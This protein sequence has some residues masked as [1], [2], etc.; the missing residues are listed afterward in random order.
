MMSACPA[1]N[2]ARVSETESVLL[3]AASATL[4]RPLRLDDVVAPL[5]LLGADS[6]GIIELTAAVEDAIGVVVPPDL[7]HESVTIRELAAWID[8]S[9]PP[10]STPALRSDPFEQMFADAV[11]PDDVRPGTG[12]SGAGL[13]EARDILLTGATGFLGARL[14]ADLLARSTAKLHC[15]VR[16]GT[17]APEERLRRRLIENGAEASAISSRVSTIEADLARPHLGLDAASRERLAASIDRVLHVGASVNWIAPYTALRNSNVQGT[18]EL[19]RL[20][21]RPVPIPFHFVSSLSVCYAAGGPPEVDELYDP[22]PHLRNVHLGYAQTKV[23][24]EALVREAGRRGLPIRIY[25]PSLISGDSHTGAFNPDDLLSLLIRGCIR[26]GLAPDLDW[27]LDCEPVDIVSAGILGLSSQP[28]QTTHLAHV[29]PRHWRE[30]LLW[31]RVTGHDVRLVP[32]QA[33]LE[34]LDAGIA[35]CPDHPL[36]SLRTFLR[37]R[38]A[39]GLT[40]PELYEDHRRTRASSV[41][42]NVRLQRLERPAL[43]ASLLDRYF[44]TYYEAG[45]V[46]SPANRASHGTPASPIRPLDEPFFE[47]ALATR[48]RYFKVRSAACTDSG[49]EHSIISE[50]T[51]W[52]SRRP[53][54]LFRYSLSIE[55]DRGPDKINVILKLKPHAD[56]VIAVGEALARLCDTRVGEAFAKWGDRTGLADSHLRER[57]LYESPNGRLTRCMPALLGVMEMDARGSCALVIEDVSGAM[58]IDSVDR[59]PSWNPEHIDIVIRDLAGIHASSFGNV[60]SLRALPW[61]GFVQTTES[62]TG[63]SDLWR[64]LADHAAPAFAAW[65]GSDVPDVHRKLVDSMDEWQRVLDEGPQALIH[66]DFNPRNICLRDRDGRLSLC[67]YDWELATLGAPQRDLAELLCF[68]LPDTATDAAI[69][70]WIERHRAALARSAGVSID[71]R[72]WQRGFHAAL[73]ELLVN[74]LAMYALVQ[75]VRRQSFLPRVL[76]TWRRLHAHSEAVTR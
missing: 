48:G 37:N 46:P 22:L 40:L 44:T 23:V 54:G 41:R 35:T 59:T 33:W 64:A 43:D 26:M 55:T 51:A 10:S 17:E 74:R 24:A 56:D 47:A 45:Y 16:P 25:R 75:R 19:L 71:R 5:S 39:L 70:H 18:L 1:S 76:A 57:A 53:S 4:R 63:M 67:A 68:V 42:T 73:N 69:D 62:M 12:R 66:N 32:Y 7:A 36:R 60:A 49:S 72:Q 14:A 11:L 21:C 58:L 28:E 9:A 52:R 2:I 30:C 50:L 6:L 13:L 27:R 31:M 3:S 29:R 61:I 34:Q 38:P 15:V 20:A 8:N 65:S